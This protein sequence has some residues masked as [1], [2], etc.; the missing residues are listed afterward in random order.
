MDDLAELGS[1]APPTTIHAGAGN[2]QLYANAGRALVAFG[3]GGDDELYGSTAADTFDGGAG[4]DVLHGGSDG[5]DDLHGGPGLDTVMY[6]GVN[7]TNVSLDDVAND[8]PKG[9][10][11]VHSD[12]ELVSTGPGD[13]RLTGDDGP[14]GLSGGD[15]RDTIDGRGGRDDLRG[16]PGDDTILARDGF[17]DTIDCGAGNDVAKIDPA[18]VAVN[19]E[20]IEYAD[21]DHDGVTA[22]RDCDDH[23]PSSFPGAREAPGDGIDQD[24]DGFDAPAI[25]EYVTTDPGASR[26]RAGFDSSWVVHAR[27][28]KVARLVAEDVPAGGQ[29]EVRCSGKG[30]GFKHKVV[31]ARRGKAS[32]TKLFRHRELKPRTAIELRVTAAGMVGRIVSFTVRAGKL[33]AKTTLCLEPG[34]ST[35]LRF[36]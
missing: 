8:G 23:D 13:D 17:R 3:D 33:P 9:I 27:Y 2:D 19:C 1:T 25:V 21:D 15:G 12:V 26:V 16:G 30:C 28:T 24:C 29:V 35:P 5:A 34:G 32:L 14:N 36:A 20:T 7:P 11:N 22:E 31:A 4:D 6:P 10:A 18:D